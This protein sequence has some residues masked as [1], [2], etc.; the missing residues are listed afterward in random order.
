MTKKKCI[1]VFRVKE[2][3]EIKK[4]VREKELKDIV[5]KVVGKVQEEWKIHKAKKGN[6]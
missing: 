6:M 2:I 4:A 1:I 3:K 5:N